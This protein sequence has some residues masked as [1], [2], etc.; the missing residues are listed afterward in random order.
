MFLNFDFFRVFKKVTTSLRKW[1][2]FSLL[3]ILIMKKVPRDH[4]K[5]L[6]DFLK[7]EP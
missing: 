6:A 7:S 1:L 2:I 5:V 4:E 3:F